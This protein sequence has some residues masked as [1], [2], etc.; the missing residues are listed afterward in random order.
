MKVQVA[1]SKFAMPLQHVKEEVRDEV[2]FLHADNQKGYKLIATL[3]AP[4]FPAR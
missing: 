4:K 1:N 3:W 2:D